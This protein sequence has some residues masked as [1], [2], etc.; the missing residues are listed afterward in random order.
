MLALLLCTNAMSIPE[1]YEVDKLPSDLW[2]INIKECNSVSEVMLTPK[3][4]PCQSAK[5]VLFIL[6]R[7]Y[8]SS[9]LSLTRQNCA[10][11]LQS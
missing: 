2:C 9:D 5:E 8:I 11:P 4:L 3:P 10:L 1:P 6:V 7:Y